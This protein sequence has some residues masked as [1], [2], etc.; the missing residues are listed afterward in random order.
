MGEC[1]GHAARAVHSFPWWAAQGGGPCRSS[2]ALSSLPLVCLQPGKLRK[3]EKKNSCGRP[4]PYNAPSRGGA[5]ARGGAHR[6]CPHARRFVHSKRDKEGYPAPLRRLPLL[7]LDP[8][9]PMPLFG[10]TSCPCGHPSFLFRGPFRFLLRSLFFGV[11]RHLEASLHFDFACVP[12]F[13]FWPP[14]PKKIHSSTK[15]VWGG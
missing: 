10:H 12:S 3:G 8:T 7:L 4:W 14:P 9:S 1:A 5:M 13:G 15:G 6:R 11:P 2:L